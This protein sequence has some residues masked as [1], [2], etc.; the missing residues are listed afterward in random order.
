M[1][2]VIS[3]EQKLLLRRV[4]TE[5]IPINARNILLLGIWILLAYWV[6]WKGGIWLLSALKENQGILATFILK[7]IFILL[8][9]AL[10]IF[11][12]AFVNEIK[13]QYA[14]NVIARN[15]QVLV[16]SQAALK[17]LLEGQKNHK[18]EIKFAHAHKLI[19]LY[20]VNIAFDDAQFLKIIKHVDVNVIP[21]VLDII[22]AFRQLSQTIQNQLRS[23]E[24]DQ[25]NRS[26]RSVIFP[27][28]LVDVILETDINQLIKRLTPK[29]I[30]QVSEPFEKAA[31]ATAVAT[32]ESRLE[33]E[34]ARDNSDRVDGQ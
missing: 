22:V 24:I 14:R 30:A 23:L 15:L 3:P 34:D 2:K 26:N 6:F 18:K 17:K 29:I 20:Y 4:F 32:V 27:S 7:S 10:S 28:E 33:V 31:M 13:G 19:P 5:I 11:G 1:S 12:F 25:V 9:V 8:G 16:L 21:E